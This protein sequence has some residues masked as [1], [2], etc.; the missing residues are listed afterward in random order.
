MMPKTLQIG[1]PNDTDIVATR[2]FKAPPSLVFDCHTKPEL[3][4][5][6]QSGPEGWEWTICEIDLRVGGAYHYRWR[7]GEGVE[8]GFRG[9]YLEIEP[10][11]KI[12]HSETFEGGN[13]TTV[14]TLLLEAKDGGTLMT[15]TMRTPSK[16]VRDAMIASGMAGGMEIGYGRLDR[17][18]AAQTGG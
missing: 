12:V 8:I 7:N 17:Y 1:T 5:L 11:T 15:Y 2:F 6:W 10:P 3:V 9:T 18:L 4:R 14:N 16:A 13:D